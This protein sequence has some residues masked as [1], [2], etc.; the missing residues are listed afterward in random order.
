MSVLIAT[1]VQDA[2][3]PLEVRK[4][5]PNE[6][7]ALR[8]CLGWSILSGSV[9]CSDKHQFN[10]DHVSYEQI[11]LSGQLE[12]F[13]WVESHGTVKRSLKSMSVED[14]KAWRLSRILSQR[15]TAIIRSAYF[16]SMETL[17]YPAIGPLLKPDFII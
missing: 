10:L 4:G 1:D 5:E 12:D 2:I 15:L 7:F 6:P 3:I 11:S 16:R 14:R 17:T 13:W 8:P 9:S